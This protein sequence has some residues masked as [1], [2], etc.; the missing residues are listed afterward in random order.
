MLAVDAL[1]YGGA[2]SSCMICIISAVAFVAF[3]TPFFSEIA[4]IFKHEET[5]NEKRERK[6]VSEKVRA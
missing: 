1:L 4:E 5:R 6:S 3:S 2:V